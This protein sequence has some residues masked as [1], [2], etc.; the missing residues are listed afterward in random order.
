MKGSK[1]FNLPPNSWLI[2]PGSCAIS[3]SQCR[4]L[5]LIDWTF[6]SGHSHIGL[7]EWKYTAL[8]SCINVM[9]DIMVTL[10]RSLLG[11]DRGEWGKRFTCIN[12]IG[13]YPLDY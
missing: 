13:H 5:L 6:S 11:D 2:T 9:P 1:I 3:E 10:F 7:G 12:R 4:S 8:S